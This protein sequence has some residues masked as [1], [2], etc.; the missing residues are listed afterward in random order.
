MKRRKVKHSTAAHQDYTRLMDFLVENRGVDT[1]FA[2]DA[3]LERAVQSLEHM[4]DRGRVV[5]ELHDRGYTEYR[6]LIA[7]PY[8][9]VYKP[10]SRDEVWIVAIVEGHRE[11]D[12]LL[13]ERAR[14]LGLE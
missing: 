5:P 9:I 4:P 6:E 14:R 10:I 11:L 1:A 7:A 3:I 13:L 2:V 8:R 12:E